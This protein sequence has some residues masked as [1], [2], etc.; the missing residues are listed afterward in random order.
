MGL[1]FLVD[2]SSVK[3]TAPAGIPPADLVQD[4]ALKKALSVARRWPHALVLG[5]DTI[6]VL[7]STVYG[8]PSDEWAAR[9]MLQML[10]GRTHTVYTGIALVQ[11]A[12]RRRARAV[13]SADVTFA[14]LLR[15]E[16]DRYVATGAPMDKAGGYGI[17]DDWGCV[18]VER[19]D[20]DYF[21]VVGLPL[22]R[23]YRLLKHDF[24]DLC[25][26]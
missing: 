1:S 23:L 13:E 3:E 14:A 8:K 2:P 25:A 22:S 17:Q 16:I 9:K 5:S 18:F 21:T 24:A 10:S 20:G 11:E 4:L 19:I 12:S 26:Y 6:V 7:D 15:E